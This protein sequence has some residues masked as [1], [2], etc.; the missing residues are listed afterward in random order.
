MVSSVIVQRPPLPRPRPRSRSLDGLLDE[1]VKSNVEE[2]CEE[3]NKI[4]REKNHS[5]TNLEENKTILASKENPKKPNAEAIEDEPRPVPRTKSKMADSEFQSEMEDAQT[6]SDKDKNDKE[7][8]LTHPPKP[9]RH[10]NLEGQS[11]TSSGKDFGNQECQVKEQKIREMAQERLLTRSNDEKDDYN[12]DKSTILLKAS[13]SCGAGLDSDG[14]IS[15]SDYS[16]SGARAKG[17]GSLL[18]LPAGAEPKRKRN[19]MDKCVNKVRS[20]IKK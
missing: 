16:G 13:R 10:S 9:S 14:S 17:P 12:D 15:S 1:D 7:T 20:F 18:S 8:L 3:Q 6:F 4:Q 19:F 5:L 11:S 2:S